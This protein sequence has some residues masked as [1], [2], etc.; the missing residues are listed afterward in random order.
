MVAVFDEVRI[1]EDVEKG[2]KGG[3]RFNTGLVPLANGFERRNQNWSQSRGQWD[4]GYGITTKALFSL[5]V[6]FFYARRGRARGFRFKDWTDFE[7]ARQVVGTTDTATTDFQI[8]V[9]YTSGSVTFDRTLYKIVSGTVSVWVNS[10]SITEGAGVG[11]FSLDYDTGVLTLG[12]T[13]AAQSGTDV[14]VECEFDVPVRFDTDAL[15]LVAERDD[16][17]AIPVIPIIEVRT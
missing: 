9:R 16:V 14:E 11:E 12:S 1:D 5:V 3:P 7:M 10:V 8:F 15:D 2:A 6:E 4:I 13:L 17:A